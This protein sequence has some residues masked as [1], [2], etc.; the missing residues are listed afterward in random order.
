MRERWQNLNGLWDYAVARRTEPQ[1][2]KFAGKIL[3]PFA[4]ESALSGVGRPFTPDDRLW[5]RRGF[6]V[7]RD[8][9]GQ[10][11]LL[12]FGAVDYECTLWV[13]GGLVG[14]HTGGSDPFT[15]DITPFL[16]ERPGAGGDAPN[17]LVLA[18]TD[19]TDTG[20][21]PRGKQQLDPRG[22]WYTPVSG[23][24]QTVWMEPVPAGVSLRELRLTPDVEAGR[25]R[26]AALVNAAVE[27]DTLAVRCTAPGE[28]RG[29]RVDDHPRQPRGM[30]RNSQARA[31]DAREP[32][33]LRPVG[34][35]GDRS[36]TPGARASGP[37]SGRSC[38]RSA[39]RSGRPTPGPR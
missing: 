14:S 23:I 21:Q 3:V 11:V 10:R 20:E 30:A 38:R 9:D 13:N 15:F 24:W 35:A 36:R 28:G 16:R 2:A 31:L 25:L 29:D 7:P 33:P 22:I 39:R 19:P 37:R 4:L 1:P 32:V 8:W 34:R 27:D 26:V 12:H 18:V 5:Y 6:A 17:E